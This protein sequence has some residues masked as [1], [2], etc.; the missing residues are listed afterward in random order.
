[1]RHWPR[2]DG[3]GAR[4]R[5][6]HDRPADET[7]R[8]VGGRCLHALIGLR[9][10]AHL[11]N[12]RHAELGG[13]LLLPAVRLR[14][15][16]APTAPK[17]RSGADLAP[18]IPPVLAVEGL[19]VSVRTEFGVKPL[20]SDLSLTLRRGETLCIAGESGSGKSIT[21]LAIMGLLPPPAVR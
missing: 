4:C 10:S 15:N 21:S 20:V 2:P 11:G 12:R 9:R 6:Q 18:D 7:A 19:T 8:D 14:M 3:G 16:L 5:F 17:S 1:D 13:K